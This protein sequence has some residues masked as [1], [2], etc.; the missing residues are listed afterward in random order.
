MEKLLREYFWRF[1]DPRFYGCRLFSSYF[2]FKFYF[3]NLFI[4]YFI[5]DVSYLLGTT[6][7]L[8]VSSF[9]ISFSK[10]ILLSSNSSRL[11][12]CYLCFGNAIYFSIEVVGIQTAWTSGRSHHTSSFKSQP[13]FI[14]WGKPNAGTRCMSLIS[15]SPILCLIICWRWKISLECS[16]V[17]SAVGL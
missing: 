1:Q 6:F 12:F 4:N 15:S 8:S 16:S 7:I 5:F 9:S 13:T 11:V 17:M 2:S 10:C 14:N 3:W